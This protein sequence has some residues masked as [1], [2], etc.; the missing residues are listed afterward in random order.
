MRSAQ[1]LTAR[2]EWAATAEPLGAFRRP[3]PDKGQRPYQRYPGVYP[4][5]EA[6]EDVLQVNPLLAHGY[7][8]KTRFQALLAACDL[9]PL[10]PW[11]QAAATSKLQSF[12]SVARRFRRDYDTIQAA[13][14][15]PW[16]TGRCEGQI[17]RVKLI[18]RLGYGHA[19]LAL[20]RQWTLHRMVTSVKRA[21]RGCQVQQPA[22][23]SN[24]LVTPE[25]H[26][27]SNRR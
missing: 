19:K 23:A 22:A 6:L 10:K 21:G 2:T 16:S 15:M 7:Q 5:G 18:K 25:E 20:L 24:A 11:L 4:E 9:P 3:A 27:R 1:L 14:T 26:I 8:L 13:L 12:E 17:C